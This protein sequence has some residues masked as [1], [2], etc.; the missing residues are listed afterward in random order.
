[1]LFDEL[2]LQ[3]SMT[4]I[5]AP[6]LVAAITLV[7]ALAVAGWIGGAALIL[8]WSGGA[9]LALT[10]QVPQAAEPAAQRS[11][12][13]LSAIRAV[14]EATPGVA[15][16]Q[17]LSNEQV[18][19]LLR[20]W[21]G[22]EFD[23]LNVPFPAVIAVRMTD[24]AADLD[25]LATRLTQSASGTVMED[26][27]VWADPLVDII[28]GLRLCCNLVL[29]VVTLVMTAVVAIVT[30]W[31]FWVRSDV[32]RI[33]SQIGASDG[34]IAQRFALRGASLAYIGGVIGGL[35]SLPIISAQTALVMPLIAGRAIDFAGVEA[36]SFL[37]VQFL[38]L[39]IVLP[40][41]AAAIS[42]CTVQVAM[43]RWLRRMP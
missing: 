21:L 33:I 32:I 38:L 39:P 34:Y 28:R 12:T 13:R 9:A 30:R 19:A 7:A 4:D 18:S 29:V 16:T 37:S 8:H 40:L 11:D 36:F 41:S 22:N 43:R 6:L 42:Y 5:A 3:L 2:G 23:N 10:I 26:H 35:L 14:L 20:P 1:L 15:S 31:E 27:A 24:N 17:T 25:G